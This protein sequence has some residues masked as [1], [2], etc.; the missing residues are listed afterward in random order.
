MTNGWFWCPCCQRAFHVDNCTDYT[1]KHA[2]P[3]RANPVTRPSPAN[4]PFDDCGAPA[5]CMMTWLAVRQWA[6]T[7]YQREFPARPE[8]GRAYEMPPRARAE[9]PTEAQP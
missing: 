6:R 7:I 4:C 1:A 8:H 5:R 3:L 9:R 2:G